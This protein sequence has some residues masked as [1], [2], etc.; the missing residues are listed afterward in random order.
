MPFPV[1]RCRGKE[2]QT[3]TLPGLRRETSRG[4]RSMKAQRLDRITTRL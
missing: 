4:P 3:R 2:P 1:F